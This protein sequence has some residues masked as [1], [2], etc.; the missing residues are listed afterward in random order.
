MP[1]TETHDLAG[2]L[3]AA[4]HDFDWAWRGS[5][6][7]GTPSRESSRY[8][9]GSPRARVPRLLVVAGTRRQ[10]VERRSPPSRAPSTTP[11]LVARI[12]WASC[13]AEIAPIT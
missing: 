9:P 13:C 4:V 5:S 7:S 2:E 12:P 10:R 1:M 11:D 6:S 3:A 8:W